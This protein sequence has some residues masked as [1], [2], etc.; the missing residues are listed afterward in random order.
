MHGQDIFALVVTEARGGFFP[1]LLHSFEASA[2]ELQHQTIFCNTEGD[3]ARQGETVLQLI[4]REVSG[5][6]IHLTNLAPTP[7]YH[8]R[9]LHKH[10]IPVVFLHRRVE[11][12]SAPSLM[13]PFHEIGHLCR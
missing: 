9:Q 7:V 3:I 11:G 1:S 4:D 10:G 12:I 6:A 2:G 13:L 8:I 5:V